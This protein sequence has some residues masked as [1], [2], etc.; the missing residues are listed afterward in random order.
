MI[1]RIR[2][3]PIDTVSSTI[4]QPALMNM[5]TMSTQKTLIHS[6]SVI[7]SMTNTVEFHIARA[8]SIRTAGFPMHR[9]SISRLQLGLTRGASIH[10]LPARHSM[11]PMRKHRSLVSLPTPF[12]ASLDRCTFHPQVLS[13][14]LQTLSQLLTPPRR[15]QR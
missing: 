5:V 15:N 13:L 7:H 4:T 1:V 14:H 10:L 2:I 8:T 9:I 12:D 11:L 3:V 6:Q